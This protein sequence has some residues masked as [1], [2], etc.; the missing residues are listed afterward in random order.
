MD[1][2]TEKEDLRDVVTATPRQVLLMLTGVSTDRL[3]LAKIMM[4]MSHAA[5]LG[6][7]FCLING[8]RYAGATRF[9]GN[10]CPGPHGKVSFED[11]K[12]KVVGRLTKQIEATLAPSLTHEEHVARALKLEQSRLLAQAAGDPS[13][14]D[15]PAEVG[16]HGLS[17]VIRALPYLRYTTAFQIGIFHIL[18]YGVVR[19]FVGL[20]LP[21]KPAV[22]KEGWSFD[23]D[24][25]NIIQRRATRINLSADFNRTYRCGAGWG[26]R[27]A[28]K[29]E[30]RRK[31]TPPSHTHMA[32]TSFTTKR[33]SSWR[34]GCTSWR[35]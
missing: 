4:C 24:A 35:Q 18:L 1:Y 7:P 11:R 14:A 30:G 9:L 16:C 17:E 28:R 25:R 34:S 3:A 21:K 2:T 26:E 6:C 19:D 29:Q 23:Q 8:E 10:G 12:N 5:I 15:K 13:L 20:I 32:E 33:P 31:R 27:E 22:M